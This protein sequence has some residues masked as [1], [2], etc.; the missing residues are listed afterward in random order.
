[1]IPA[2]LL[3]LLMPLS[4]AVVASLQNPR[5]S[6]RPPLTKEQRMEEKEKEEKEQ[7]EPV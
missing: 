3:P 1:M 4:V 7:E 2:L 6:G 5:K